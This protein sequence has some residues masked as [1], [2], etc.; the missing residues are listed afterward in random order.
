[1]YHLQLSSLSLSPGNLF[2]VIGLLLF[3]WDTLIYVWALALVFYLPLTCTSVVA[4][5]FISLFIFKTCN[6][7]MMSVFRWFSN[8]HIP[9]KDC[10]D[11]IC[12]PLSVHL[13]KCLWLTTIFQSFFGCVILFAYFCFGGMFGIYFVVRLFWVGWWLSLL[14]TVVQRLD[15]FMPE[16]EAV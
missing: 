7:F 5:S 11:L 14:V 12:A 8:L 4:N 13:L 16:W 15:H 6:C 1:M 10:T 3:F 9:F 2:G